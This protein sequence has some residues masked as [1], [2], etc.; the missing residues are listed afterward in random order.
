MF[1]GFG[2]VYN[3]NED[4]FQQFISHN[5]VCIGW[6]MSDASSWHSMM[7]EMKIGDIVFLKSFPPKH[8]LYIK[9]IGIVEFSTMI[10]ISN[11]GYGRIVRWK[12]VLDQDNWVKF[13]RLNDRYD[14]FRSGTAYIEFNHKVQS[15]IIELI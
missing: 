13:G 11:L 15:K 4:M 1:Y 6:E 7:G 8:G 2:C 3:G 14:Q 12:T 10:P 9:A 5:C